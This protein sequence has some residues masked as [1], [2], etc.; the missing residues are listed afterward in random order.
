MRRDTR[1]LKP[2]AAPVASVSS[3]P[4]HPHPSVAAPSGHVS[5]E[6]SSRSSK[7]LSLVWSHSTS[8]VP[9]ELV[10][11]EVVALVVSKVVATIVVGRPL[12]SHHVAAVAP[13]TGWIAATIAC[14]LVA[15]IVSS[16]VVSKVPALVSTKVSSL[17]ATKVAA[18]TVRKVSSL[19]PTKVVGRPLAH[20][21][22]HP[23]HVAAVV[24]LLVVSIVS[25]RVAGKHSWPGTSHV[26]ISHLA[27]SSSSTSCSCSSSTT[28]VPGS[29]VARSR[30]PTHVVPHV[31]ASLPGRGSHWSTSVH[32]AASRHGSRSHGSPTASHPGSSSHWWPTGSASHATHGSVVV[33][34][35]NRRSVNLK[36]EKLI[37]F[38]P[39]VVLVSF[40]ISWSLVTRL[41]LLQFS[42]LVLL[43]V[44]LLLGHFVVQLYNLHGL[45]S[46]QLGEGDLLEHWNHRV[47]LIL[48]QTIIG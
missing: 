8:L 28:L 47:S 34:T 4:G 21:S 31:V 33:A 26:H 27:H 23:T 1:R 29:P 17:V 13:G 15:A 5:S 24:A 36:Y 32:H 44:T 14:S 16:L 40:E 18:K 10:P 38:L 42:V 25:S 19:A 12:T 6:V 30:S 39:A 7:I 46:V 37:I 20:R 22:S 3:T 9:G 35:E 43:P 11:A 2:P 48:W 41:E 45:L